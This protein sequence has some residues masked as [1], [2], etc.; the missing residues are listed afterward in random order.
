MYGKLA[1]SHR[2][3]IFILG[4]AFGLVIG[5]S[6]STSAGYLVDGFYVSFNALPAADITSGLT[7]TSLVVG[8]TSFAP[9]SPLVQS[10]GGKWLQGTSSPWGATNPFQFSS[11]LNGSVYDAIV[12]GTAT[13][14]YGAPQSAL[15]ILWGT[16][17]GQNQLQFFAQNGT[18]LGTLTGT[19]LTTAANAHDPGFTFANGVDITVQPTTPYYSVSTSSSGLT[20]EY[21]N[22][23]STAATVPEPSSVAL[24][25]FGM[26]ALASILAKTRRLAK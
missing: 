20:F 8:G 19:D 3:T 2:R 21:S 18:S 10:G 5:A 14:A 11:T 24:L 1:R 25:G 15:S 7:P 17:D 23:V 12:N 4:L 16:P 9:T 22:I 13:Y 26:A 6:G